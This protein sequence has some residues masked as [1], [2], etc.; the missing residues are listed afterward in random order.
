[1]VLQVKALPAIILCHCA[2]FGSANGLWVWFVVVLPYKKRKEKEK[3][4]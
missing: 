1:V 2:L 3:E 4:K